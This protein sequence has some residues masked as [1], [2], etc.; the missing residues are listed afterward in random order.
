[1]NLNELCN[2]VDGQT[3]LKRVMDTWGKTRSPLVYWARQ[4]AQMNAMGTNGLLQDI[5]SVEKTVDEGF[6]FFKH[7]LPTWE[8]SNVCRKKY[9]NDVVKLTL[10]IASPK[11]MQIKKDVRVT[12]ADQ[13]GVIG[14]R[15]SKHESQGSPL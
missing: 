13:L 6:T 8:T 2:E 11:A 5:P 3:S 7:G 14:K 10:Q 12:F 4:M 1:M 15:E 9:R